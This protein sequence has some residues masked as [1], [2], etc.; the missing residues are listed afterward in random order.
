MTYALTTAALLERAATAGHHVKADQLTR[1]HRLGL[2]RPPQ[3]IFL[4]RGR[5]T[6]SA[7][8]PGTAEQLI[9]LCAI[10]S[11]T[12]RNSRI[13]GWQLWN[14]G[15]QVDV[16]YW[17]EPLE[18]AAAE[19]RH[20]VG[21]TTETID[22]DQESTP[23]ISEFGVK[24]VDAA[25]KRRCGTPAIGTIRRRTGRIHFSSV[26]VLMLK[27]AAGVFKPSSNEGIQDE[28]EEQRLIFGKLLGENAAASTR[29][30]AEDN[31]SFFI[32]VSKFEHILELFTAVFRRIQK[33]G[34][35]AGYSEIEIIEARNELR[36]L[37]ALYCSVAQLERQ[38]YGCTSPALQLFLEII[39]CLD[40]HRHAGMILLWLLV[41]QVPSIGQGAQNLLRNMSRPAPLV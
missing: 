26:L 19:F 22:D 8:Q 15:Y 39:E 31:S 32:S 21:R 34:L 7:Y 20:A 40:V 30:Q 16:R 4:G 12:G 33:N 9:A 29:Q 41:R 6:V 18:Y 35:F 11:R 17:R 27:V 28:A 1:W 3:R 14:A 25:C 38:I 5:G 23:I 24:V 36:N 37:S 10:L 2:L 13:A